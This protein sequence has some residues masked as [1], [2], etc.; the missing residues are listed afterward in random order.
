MKTFKIQEEHK[1]AVVAQ[2]VEMQKESEKEHHLRQLV[3]EHEQKIEHEKLEKEMHERQ[4]KK[5]EE[6]RKIIA[7]QE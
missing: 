3:R 1:K 2:E 4:A 5:I 6:G 7:K